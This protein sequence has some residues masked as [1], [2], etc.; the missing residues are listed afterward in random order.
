MK[1]SVF[2]VLAIAA[3]PVVSSAAPSGPSAK[4]AARLKKY[5]TSNWLAH[6][7]PDDRYKIA[8]GVWKYVS[9]DLDTYFHR[10]YSAYMLRQPA[11]RV[12]GFSSAAEA[13]EAGYRPD[14]A[15]NMPRVTITTT[16]V[17][18]VRRF[19]TKRQRAR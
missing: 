6:Y 5:P 15:L 7:L 11:G 16:Q 12:I 13:I 18:K 4:M 3:M 2:L 8:G 1:T 10:P 19:Q 17:K 9:T 14:P